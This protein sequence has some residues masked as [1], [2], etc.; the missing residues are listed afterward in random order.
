MKIT[1]RNPFRFFIELRHQQLWIVYWVY[2][3]VI[4]NFSSA[5]FWN[6]PLAKVIFFTFIISASS[7]IGLYSRFGFEK[8]IGLGHIFWVPLLFFLLRQINYSIGKY[9]I[10]LIVLTL[11]IIISLIFDTVDVWNYFTRK[12]S[13]RNK[14]L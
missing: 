13:L 9:R 4:L 3:L 12:K 8:I 6:K 10:Y 14:L 7:I 5:I 11:S 2:Y 1:V